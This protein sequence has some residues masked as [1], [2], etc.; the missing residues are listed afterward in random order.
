LARFDQDL[1]VQR[2]KGKLDNESCQ[3]VD[4]LLYRH[5]QEKWAY[6][7]HEDREWRISRKQKIPYLFPSDTTLI[8]DVFY[9]QN[10]LRFVSDSICKRISR[11]IVIDG[12]AASGDSAMVF[13]EYAPQKVYA[14][15]PSTQQIAEIE[16]TIVLNNVHE[17]IEVIPFGLSQQTGRCLI[18]DQRQVVSDISTTTLDSFCVDKC[19]SL[20]KLDIE[21]AEL[22]AIKGAEKTIRRDR[23]LMLISIYHRPEDFFEIKPLIESWGL[24]YSF[25]I[26]NTEVGNNLAGV[27]AMLICYQKEDN[28]RTL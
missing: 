27:H 11:G 4:L 20:I 5:Q 16:E 25:M 22:A 6:S 24:D 10:G 3:L 8:H 2:L 14:F 13:L 17:K 12:G 18:Q 28:L 26:R 1:A 23:P 19:V 7:E 15:E 21:G 9:Y